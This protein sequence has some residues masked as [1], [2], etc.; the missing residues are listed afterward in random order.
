MSKAHLNRNLEGKKR[1]TEKHGIRGQRKN[2]SVRWVGIS[3]PT[4]CLLFRAHL[5][6]WY[7][8]SYT[9]CVLALIPHLLCSH[10]NTSLAHSSP[11]FTLYSLSLSNLLRV[12]ERLWGRTR[13][14]WSYHAIFEYMNRTGRGV[15]FLRLWTKKTQWSKKNTTHNKHNPQ[16]QTS[17][18]S[19]LE[20]TYTHTC[21]VVI[22]SMH[23]EWWRWFLLIL[24]ATTSSLQTSFLFMNYFF[25]LVGPGMVILGQN[26]EAFAT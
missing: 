25:L 8:Y 15:C 18:P 13:L 10:G 11:L 19:G 26:A 12:N 4:H 9:S 6:S 2:M 16:Q 20:S 3:T 17:L 5:L 21:N 24:C 23:G 14:F 22:A 7:S 1:L